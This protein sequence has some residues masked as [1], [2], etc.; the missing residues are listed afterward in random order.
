MGE[1][2]EF[3]ALVLGAVLA[4][5]VKRAIDRGVMALLTPLLVRCHLSALVRAGARRSGTSGKGVGTSD[6][7]SDDTRSWD[8]N[9][10]V[11]VGGAPTA[12]R[13]RT[14]SG[15]DRYAGV[16]IGTEHDQDHAD[17]S[18]QDGPPPARQRADADTVRAWCARQLSSGWSYTEVV[19]DGMRTFNVSERTMKRRISE[20]Q[21]EDA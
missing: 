15:H 4:Y 19:D 8:P 13:V 17:H 1:D 14:V 18:D 16:R 10:I 6:G 12:E 5:G 7:T 3:L 11:M 2:L 9:G 21:G 20:A